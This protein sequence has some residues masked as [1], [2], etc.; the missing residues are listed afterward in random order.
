MIDRM[1]RLLGV[2][3]I[4]IGLTLAGGCRQQTQEE[5]DQQIRQQAQQA[6]EQARK[7]AKVAAA[8]ARVAAEKATRELKDVAQ[9]VRDGLHDSGSSSSRVDINA[10]SRDRLAGLPGITASR[11]RAIIDGRPYDSTHDLVK[12]G[13]L[14]EAQYERISGQIT[15]K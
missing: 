13:V 3:G 9:G 8:N 4:G 1:G 5:Q 15:A 10:A 14:T 2:V 6:T 12:K 7:D 11:A